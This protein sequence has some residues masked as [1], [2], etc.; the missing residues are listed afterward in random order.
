MEKKRK[1]TT[2]STADLLALRTLIREKAEFT[3]KLFRALRRGNPN[4]RLTDSE[5]A[6]EERYGYPNEVYR[7]ALREIKREL[8]FRTDDVLA[9]LD[10]LRAA[11]PEQAP[12][13]PKQ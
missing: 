8:L 9:Y 11:R 1:F 6:F 7:I 10:T 5:R 12:V 4:E 2:C 13:N 3:D